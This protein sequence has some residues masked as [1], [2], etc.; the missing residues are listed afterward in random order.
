MVPR[1][2][3]KH[4][5]KQEVI[6]LPIEFN[7][8]YLFSLSVSL[9]ILQSVGLVFWHLPE[10]VLEVYPVFFV[11]CGQMSG[12]LFLAFFAMSISPSL[13]ESSQLERF[14]RPLTFIGFR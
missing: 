14:K 7:G 13:T 6:L 10:L 5:Y 9:K 2:F 4:T 8:T 3:P 1:R 11:T 12:R